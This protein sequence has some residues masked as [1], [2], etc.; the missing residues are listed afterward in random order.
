MNITLIG[1]T[2]YVGSALL[3]EAL[4]RG[5]QVTAIARDTAK[6]PAHAGLTAK[7]VALNDA[8]T[9]AT[10]VRGSDAVISA[11]NGGWQNPNIA[12]DTVNGYAAIIEGAK[13]AGVPRLLVVGGA[14]SLEVAPGQRLIDQP[15][16]PAEH[17]AGAG[18][19][20]DVLDTLRTETQLD[21]S[22]LSPAAELVS[23]ER[24][25]RYRVGGDQLLVDDQGHS[26]ISVQDYAVAMLDEL[27]Q[28]AHS[29]KRFSVAY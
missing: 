5:H 1:A 7:A 29:R 28:P 27:E 13:R 17:K 24:S 20:R 2:G 11:F 19:M 22:F 25:G 14:G 26:R 10:A 12:A 9:V 15:A 8:A 4:E 21:W 23:G 3:N 18:A 16:F 6:L